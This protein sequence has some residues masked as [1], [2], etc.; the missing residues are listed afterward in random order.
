MTRKAHLEPHLS[1]N[2]LKTRYQ[3]TTD[4]VESRRW[5]LL[6]LVSQKWTI[7]Q[8]A[9]AVGLNY[10]YAKDIV[11]NYNQQG[12]GGLLN[13]RKIRSTRRGKPLLDAAQIEEL[14]EC[15]QKPPE[16]KGLWTGPKVAAWIA[17][18]TGRKK[19]WAQRGWEY[20]KKCRYSLQIPRPSHQKGDKEQQEQF[21]QKLPQRVKELQH[22]S[23]QSTIEVWSFDEHRLGLK[24]ICRRVWAPIGERPLASVHHRYEWLYLYGY[25]HPQTGQK[26]WFIVPRVN[27][28]W[29]NLVLKSFAE[30]VGASK[31][32]I[33][34]L[35]V[36]RAGWHMSEKVELP[37][38]I[39]LEPLPP[40]SPELQPAERLWSL[41]DEP[42]V[43]KSFSTLDELEEV[44]SERCR[45]LCQ[46]QPQI[47]ALTNYHWWPEPNTLKT[48]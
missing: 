16:D 11:R 6:W 42:L 13:R 46:M 33:I 3:L 19:V 24:P 40:Y 2:E 36:D 15:L 9:V 44:L 48:G 31:D 37:E 22:K 39:F 23:P 21:K 41:A 28:K 45:I 12:E 20:L 35:V 38:G 18:K 8:A 1:S 25:V 32:K 34:L 7:K 30:A 27:V 47:Q 4:K 5:H 26:E 43:N 29:F 14:R 17:Q 10:D